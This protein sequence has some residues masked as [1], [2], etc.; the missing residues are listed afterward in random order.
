MIEVRGPDSIDEVGLRVSAVTF[1]GSEVRAAGH[2]DEVGLRA[3]S[4]RLS[5]FQVFSLLRAG[6][7]GR[8]M[9]D[10]VVKINDHALYEQDLDVVLLHTPRRPHSVC[11]VAF[12]LS[13][14][15]VA[16]H[17]RGT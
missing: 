8:E 4:A 13:A 7:S 11:P 2:I 14:A 12:S 17:Q 3:L 15:A 1:P 9:K 16:V 5:P 10:K 6:Q